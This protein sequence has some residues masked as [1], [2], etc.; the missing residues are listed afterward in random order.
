MRCAGHSERRG[1]PGGAAEPWRGDTTDAGSTAAGA[2]GGTAATTGAP[3]TA[4]AGRASAARRSSSA[5]RGCSRA[6]G[7][8]VAGGVRCRQDRRGGVVR[9]KVSSRATG[10]VVERAARTQR[11]DALLPGSQDK[12]WYQ[13]RVEEHTPLGARV[14]F[15]GYKNQEEVRSNR[16]HCPH[17]SRVV[18]ARPTSQRWAVSTPVPV[19]NL[20]APQSK[21]RKELTDEEILSRQMPKSFSIMPGDTDEEKAKKRKMIHGKQTS[22]RMRHRPCSSRSSCAGVHH[23]DDGAVGCCAAG[24]KSKQRFAKQATEQKQKQSAWM[25]FQNAKGGKKKVR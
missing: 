18:C 17:E 3:T 9:G 23:R 5:I 16:H 25:D 13:A 20:R 22:P 12:N 2:G 1:A 8:G 14:T 11:D 19:E 24:F 7:R 15:L 21:K 4:A 6:R 10:L